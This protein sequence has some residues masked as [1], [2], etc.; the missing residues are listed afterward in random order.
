MK[1]LLT[2]LLTACIITHGWGQSRSIDSY[3]EDAVL[4]FTLDT[5][6][7][8]NG[9]EFFDSLLAD[10]H[11][12]ILGEY[13]GSVQISR[14]T[15]A[16][17]PLYAKHGGK[18]FGLE[19]GPQASRQI[20]D[21]MAR[22]TAAAFFGR[23]NGAYTIVTAERPYTPI[24]FFRSAGD[25][26]FLQTAF[27]HGL[28]TIGLDQENLFSY[29]LLIDSLIG[30]LPAADVDLRTLARTLRDSV[31]IYLERGVTAQARGGSR[32]EGL[33]VKLEES[34]FLQRALG[35]LAAGGPRA[36]EVIAS[37]RT[38]NAIYYHHGIGDWWN[39]NRLRTENFVDNF[40]EAL[41]PDGTVSEERLFLKI[42]GLH[43]AK[44][45]NNYYRYDIGNLIYETARLT[46]RKSLHTVIID[47]FWVQE[48][49]EW[50]DSLEDST[51]WLATNLGQLLQAGKPD[52]WTVI[53]LAKV[54]KQGLYGKD[55][56]PTVRQYFERY[57]LFIIPPADLEPKL[58]SNSQPS[59]RNMSTQKGGLQGTY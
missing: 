45:M 47:R 37:L 38:S 15:N 10:N 33:A 3:L 56:H 21:G 1:Y 25:A 55:V 36:E 35:A 11:Y 53:D 4:H 41:V 27:D 8:A 44:G 7:S 19:I 57:D 42:G 39:S 59:G 12:F 6:L 31:A 5:S 9:R 14:L 32:R 18:V 24:P 13:H 58:L 23:L 54:R 20:N 48:D 40:R 28:T 26:R 43:A 29:P 51:S 17:L 46:G 49:G 16:L 22:E 50:T 52:R 2:T 34:A 30:T